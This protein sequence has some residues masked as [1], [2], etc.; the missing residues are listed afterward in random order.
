[1]VELKHNKHSVGQSA[2][3]FVFRPKYNV[4]VFRHP[5]VKQV[6]EEAF[7]ETAEKHNIEIYE[8]KV[9]PDH[10][11]M[12]VGLPTQI[13]IS[14]AFQLIKGASSRRILQKCT[15]WRA[16]FSYDGTIK[17][18]LWS[19]GKFYRS[20]GNVKADVIEHYIS[21]SNKWD[22]DYLERTQ[23]TLEAF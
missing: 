18:H 12:F 11:H 13:S 10:V 5:W 2:Y 22:F 21:S 17:P 14:K 6:C 8:M 4:C 23:S 9:M 20:V 19:K 7:K 15:K 1:M 3:H 16:F